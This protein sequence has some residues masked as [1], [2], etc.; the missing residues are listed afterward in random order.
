MPP[1]PPTIPM[2]L[3]AVLSALVLATALPGAVMGFLAGN[4]FL[5]VLELV[6]IL[7]AAMGIPIGLGRF[8]RGPAIAI[9]CV[10]GGVATPTVLSGL[11]QLGPLMGVEVRP[12]ILGRLAIS[13]VMLACAGL[14]LV[15]RRPAQSVRYL[16]RAVALGAPVVVFAGLWWKVPAF[17]NAIDGLHP[18]ANGL[19]WAVLGLI[20]LVLV[21]V[22]AHCFIRAFEV[23]VEAGEEQA[24]ASEKAGAPA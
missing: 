24:A 18:I 11:S 3:V 7:A 17:R 13:I 21:S 5:G 22:G 8:N 4:Y 14:V 12:W 6:V 19:L 23:G 16:V 20:G 10:A 1:A 2:R 9:A 15:A